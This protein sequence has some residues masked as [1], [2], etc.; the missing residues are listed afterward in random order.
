MS[1]ERGAARRRRAAVARRRGFR[2]LDFLPVPFVR[3]DGCC[4][5]PGTLEKVHL[6]LGVSPAVKTPHNRYFCIVSLSM[7]V[8]KMINCIKSDAY[9]MTC[10]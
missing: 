9:L 1:I 2:R 7:L 4:R 10:R 3:F 6:K 5:R 8:P